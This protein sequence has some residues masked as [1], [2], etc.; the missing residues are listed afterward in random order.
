[1]PSPA[2]LH[3]LHSIPRM[4]TLAPARVAREASQTILRRLDLRR[5]SSADARRDRPAAFPVA[6]LATPST[7]AAP[8][9]LT[10]LSTLAR[11]ALTLATLTL[12]PQLAHGATSSLP[13]AAAPPVDPHSL[14]TATAP[15][16]DPHS[17]PAPAATPPSPVLDPAHP[18]APTRNTADLKAEA[19]RLF[20]ADDLPGAAVLWAQLAVQLE[21]GPD[22][23]LLIWKALGAWERAYATD[24]DHRQLC[25]ARDLARAVLRDHLRQDHR[26][27]FELRLQALDRALADLGDPST[28]CIADTA[29]L[30]T[31]H[32]AASAA[33]SSASPTAAPSP[34]SPTPAP[35]SPSTTSEHLTP[36][37]LV[38]AR[39]PAGRPYLIA[40]AITLPL[41]VALLGVMTYAILEDAR[42]IALVDR[43]DAKNQ[44]LGLTPEEA[45][46]AR[47]ALA[48]ARA[49]SYLT[50]GTGI[51]G[52][53]LTLTGTAL[54]IRGQRQRQRHLALHLALHPAVAPTGAALTLSG[55]F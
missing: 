48:R 5:R 49:A 40:G 7:L 21:P 17:L 43:Y 29:A 25:A 12:T 34:S 24:H 53:A 31:T 44:T 3:P 6:P 46:E 8:S 47:D 26:L 52:A 10:A 4:P 13:D 9:T 45:A 54:L 38:D 32:T 19:D 11:S 50:L 30:L 1:M 55:R 20:R 37:A 36:A 42:Q 15:H 41:G 33:T 18:A 28:L 39:P 23:N 27:E 35:S 51:A 2:L 16:A 14:P 22:R